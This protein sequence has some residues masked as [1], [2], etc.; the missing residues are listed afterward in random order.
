[1]KNLVV[2]I[3]PL[4]L[5]ICF[6]SCEKDP[7]DDPKEDPIELYGKWEPTDGESHLYEG[8]VL[9]GTTKL[10]I[11]WYMIQF[12]QDGKFIVYFDIEDPD[13]IEVMDWSRSGD[14]V[15]IDEDE[16][17]IESLTRQEMVFSTWESET[18]KYVF[19]CSKVN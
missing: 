11:E 9:T 7:D 8:G 19:T 5:T 16:F 15:T 3:L 18:E 4:L 12:N 14:I 17:K 13:D 2:Y 6:V 10:E 1:M